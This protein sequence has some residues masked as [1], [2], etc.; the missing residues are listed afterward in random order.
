MAM[1]KEKALM[2]DAQDLPLDAAQA[3]EEA[4]AASDAD[5]ETFMNLA[6]LYFVCTDGGYAAHHNLSPEFV[7]DAWDRAYELLDEAESRFGNQAEMTFWRH[8]FR[9]VGLGAA[10][11]I[12]TCQHLLESGDSLVPS[13]TSLRRLE[14]SPIAPKRSSSLR[15]SKRGQPPSNAIFGPSLPRGFRSLTPPSRRLLHVHLSN[16]NAWKRLYQIGLAPPRITHGGKSHSS[17]GS[18][19]RCRGFR[20]QVDSTISGP[21]PTRIPPSVP[22]RSPH[23]HQ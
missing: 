11:F 7:N 16:G 14:A 3:Y 23:P 2:L 19:F 10:P 13:S 8:Y 9:F 17:I 6:V 15:W 20:Y 21:A 18:T 12:K 1:A 5:F 22:C 4:I